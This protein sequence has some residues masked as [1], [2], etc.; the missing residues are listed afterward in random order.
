MLTTAQ[1]PTLLYGQSVNNPL[2]LSNATLPPVT[3]EAKDGYLDRILTEMFTRAKL[4]YVLIKSPPARGL[5]DANLGVIDG[6]AARTMAIENEY[7]DLVRVPEPVFHVVF[8]GLHLDPNID[9]QSWE[10]FDDYR[11]GYLRGWDFFEEKF[12]NHKN[13]NVLDDAEALLKMLEL[14]RIDIA[15][16]TIAPARYLAAQ[17][18]M[19]RPLATSIRKRS[20]LFLFLNKKHEEK[21]ATLNSALLSM[22]SDGTHDG[23]ML[24]YKLSEN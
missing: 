16:L 19:K 10:G 22:K 4:R 13:K 23:I 14:D 9:I 17:K 24:K 6:D 2:R 7:E 1:I 8:A 3:T 15:M 11:I 21:I 5:V 18:G 12:Q 20:D